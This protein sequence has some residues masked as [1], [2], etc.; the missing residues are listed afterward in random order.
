MYYNTLQYDDSFGMHYDKKV[1]NA[2]CPNCLSNDIY[3]LD[4]DYY[5]CRSCESEL[6]DFLR[7]VD[8]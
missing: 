2:A 6:D 5:Y 4:Y 8:G 7:V 1:H 3:Y